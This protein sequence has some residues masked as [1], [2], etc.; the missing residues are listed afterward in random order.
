MLAG[1]VG[2]PRRPEDTIAADA[3]ATAA[4]PAGE[5][6]LL[7]NVALQPL[8]PRTAAGAYQLRWQLAGLREGFDRFR[9]RHQAASN[10]QA[11]PEAVTGKRIDGEACHQRSVPQLR[12]CALPAA[13]LPTFLHHGSV[14]EH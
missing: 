10:G 2:G 3:A 1:C 8:L 6:V 13:A 11:A 9:T 12:Y 14:R 4:A 5:R 7:L